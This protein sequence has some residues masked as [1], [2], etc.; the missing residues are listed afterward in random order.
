VSPEGNWNGDA[1]WTYVKLKKGASQAKLDEGLKNLSDKYL[2]HLANQQRKGTFVSQPVS[3]VHYSSER[4]GE[5]NTSTRQKTISALIL[6]A[7][8]IL[9]VIWMNY[10]NLSIALARKRINV[11][12]TFR[13]LG[14]S[15]FNLIKLSL[16]ESGLI[17]LGALGTAVILYYLSR[18][19]FGQLIETPVRTGY[20]NYSGIIIL[21]LVVMTIGILVTSFISAVPLLK[22]NPALTQQRKLA[23]NSGSQWLVGFQFF[24]SCFLV[25]CSLMITKQIRFM[26]K[27]DLGIDLN[28]VLVLKGAAST[29]IDPLRRQHFN[30]FRDELLENPEFV[31]GTATMNVPGQPL[32]FRDS[33]VTLPGQRS[34]LKKEITIGNID[35]GYI[36]TYQLKVLAGE[37]FDQTPQLDSLKVLVSES[38]VRILGF[39]SAG[40]AIGQKVAMNNREQIIK[41]VV[42]DFHHEGLKKP[43]EPMI[44]T[45]AHP[46]EF[47]FYSFRIQGNPEAA[48]AYLKTV[49]SKHYPNDPLDYFFS[50]DYFN[51]QYNEEIRLSRILI[52]FTIFAI[53]VA[54]LGLFGLI[55]FFAQQRTKEIGVR[56]VN[57]ATI[58]DIMML[59]FSFFIRFEI[60][61]F[62]L[63]CPIAWYTINK[64]LQGFA[65][66]TGISWWTFLVTGVAAFLI[67]VISV[68][69]QSY[70]AATR[71][72]VEALRYE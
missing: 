33:N 26:Q 28:Q 4:S 53:I 23:K 64:W 5:L 13:K 66:Q 52:A 1:W 47:G 59:V 3:M 22:V 57:G 10:I 12:A 19:F 32:R 17:N 14:A 31:S 6:I 35:N 43:E 21:I 61:A 40:E 39:S 41:G 16:I 9:V 48:L 69:S 36:K 11:I 30:S 27:A 58:S 70:K 37:N 68:V 24:M 29:N 49:W 8:L 15:K 51:K 7:A 71:N 54:S 38:T 50:N 65:Y 34:D 18:D 60:V 72:P 42:N 63:A 20:I 62:L 45:H 56:K 44:F 55:S 2:T 46:F 25:I 67:S